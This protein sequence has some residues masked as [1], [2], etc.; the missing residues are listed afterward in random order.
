MT[1]NTP[2]LLSSALIMFVSAGLLVI[3]AKLMAVNRNGTML[4]EKRPEPIE[5]NA[6]RN[7]PAPIR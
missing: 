4:G 3:V 2:A 7:C 1:M 6:V 5:V